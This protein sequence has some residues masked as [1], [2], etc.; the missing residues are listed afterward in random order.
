LIDSYDLPFGSRK[1]DLPILSKGDLQI[2]EKQEF[3]LISGNKFSARLDKKSG[4]LTDVVSQKDTLIKS[5]PFLNLLA[6]GEGDWA[7]RPFFNKAKLWKLKKLTYDRK[8]TFIEIISSGTFDNIVQVEYK[9]KLDAAGTMI[10]EYSGTGAP[11]GNFIRESGLK[12][13][14]ADQIHKISWDRDSYWTSY[15]EIHLGMPE[16]KV[17]LKNDFKMSY[18]IKPE[19]VWENDML[20]FYYQGIKKKI[21]LTKIARATK[22]KIFRYSLYA[23]N[24]SAISVISQGNHSCR[25]DKTDAGKVLHINHQ[26]D[27]YSLLWGNYQRN[28]KFDSGFKDVVYMKIH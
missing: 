17:H 7:A 21:P 20:D 6:Y 12:F 2:E 4:L 26:F 25:L 13:V 22:D 15:P 3:V 14:A 11:E 16:G 23:Q 9:I 1:M 28:I 19:H 24:E 18:R 8:D 5:G 10:I 27:Y